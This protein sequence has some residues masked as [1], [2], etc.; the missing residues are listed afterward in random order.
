MV[1]YKISGARRLCGELDAQG[2][3]NAALP[4]LTATLLT[5]GL[6][7]IENC[8]RILDVEVLLDILQHLGCK[9]TWEEDRLLVDTASADGD[10]IPEYL[11]RKMRS[12]VILF[13]A[14]LGRLRSGEI[15]SPGGCELGPRPI[16]F[17]ISAFEQMGVVIE[18]R[19]GCLHGVL[20]HPHD[21]TINLEF[22]S[23]G[24][25]EN[26]MLLAAAL[27]CTTTIYNAA[28]EPEIE[29][30]QAMLCSMGAG[31]RG[32]GTPVLVIRGSG[33]LRPVSHTIIPDRVVAATYLIGA[34]VTGGELKL[35]H[36]QE[37]H[38]NAATTLLS[39]SGCQ[40]ERLPDGLYLKA[41]ERP[42]PLGV[43]RTMP[44]PGFPTDMQAIFM[45]YAALAQ[46]CSV[47]IE[48]IFESRFKHVPE[49]RRLGAN[50]VVDGRM[51]V[52]TGVPWLYG[53]TVRADDLRGGA[54]LILAGL[55]AQGETRVLDNGH[56]A[57]GYQTPEHFLRL[58]GA[59]IE[60]L[61]GHP[62]AL[63][64]EEERDRG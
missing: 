17:H 28:R 43:V 9:V 20:E 8:P 3:K 45:T 53:A 26:I 54:A 4:I 25:T 44:H 35:N 14:L 59:K 62:P 48:T 50:I 2:A 40:I 32:A 10:S 42:R 6:N 12:S 31:V 5:R 64:P 34:A 29:D 38:L 18:E 57:R 11:M 27:P 1:T 56:I 22:P 55:A 24:A 58:L 51:A 37:R 63:P 13:G 41:P 23:V 21:T 7:I 47:M 49:L 30:L 19:H 16:N 60:A 61:E 36:V 33:K 15:S 39:Q 52:I 46:G